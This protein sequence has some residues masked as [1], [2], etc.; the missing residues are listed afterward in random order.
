MKTLLV[1]FLKIFHKYIL[2]LFLIMIA[3]CVT[4]LDSGVSADNIAIK[5]PF[6]VDTEVEVEVPEKD[7]PIKNIAW[8]SPVP[9]DHK[10]QFILPDLPLEEKEIEEKYYL[11]S[12]DNNDYGWEYVYGIIP[13]K[14]IESGKVL[15]G[16]IPKEAAD[17]A[18]DDLIMNSITIETEKSDV[19][20]ENIVVREEEISKT[21]INERDMNAYS[22][23]KFNISLKGKG[24]IYLPDKEN[25]DIEYYGRNFTNEDTLYTFIPKVEGTYFLRF[26]YQD[27]INN[28]YKIE[29][30]NLIVVKE[31]REIIVDKT[32]SSGIIPEKEA[33]ETVAAVV[34]ESSIETMFREGNSQGLSERVPVLLKNL[35]PSV[36]K[37]LPDIA[38]LLYESEYYISAASILEN[39][40]EDNL[41]VYLT[42]YFLYL[43]GNIYE[44]D[45][46]I[47]NEKIS[48][49]YYKTLID[50]YPASLYWEDSQKRY[51]FLKRR[52]IDIR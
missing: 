12:Y 46:Q 39:L 10:H 25:R 31:A 41:F 6:G 27:L 26:Q 50:N 42:D 3:G 29:K 18:E 47:R 17:K 21:V 24:W 32:E 15:E 23:T 38:N 11:S 40:V 20:P 8:A 35:D 7:I 19:S 45:S 43:L 28:I 37:I 51:R 34:P 1:I 52:Y 16:E 48:A 44:K 36:I 2:L 9:E 13:V 22:L 30:I 4:G 5:E 14:Q 33:L 49:G